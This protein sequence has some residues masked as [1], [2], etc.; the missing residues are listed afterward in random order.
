MGFVVQHLFYS[1]RA[2]D[3]LA[4]AHIDHH[5]LFRVLEPLVISPFFHL[6]LSSDEIASSGLVQNVDGSFHDL[7]G[8]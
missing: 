7:L 1:G 8:S 2:P 5:A 6:G 4:V 3:V